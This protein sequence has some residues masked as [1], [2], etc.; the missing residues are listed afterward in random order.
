MANVEPIL[1]RPTAV[2]ERD[3]RIEEEDNAQISA[4]KKKKKK[5]AADYVSSLQI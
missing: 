5:T 1:D 2:G 4:S 3:V